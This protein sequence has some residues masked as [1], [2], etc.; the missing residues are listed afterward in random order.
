[1]SGGDV[2]IDAALTAKRLAAK[3]VHLFCLERGRD[4]AHEWEIALAEEEGVF[5]NNSWAP[6]KVLGESSVTGLSLM[7]CIS[8]F[9]SERN[10]NPTYDEKPHAR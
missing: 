6:K 10:F 2:A 8:V 3:H 1:M 7:K 9:D 4:A 5:I